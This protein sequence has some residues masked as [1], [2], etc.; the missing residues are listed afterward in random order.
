MTVGTVVYFHYNYTMCSMDLCVWLISRSSTDNLVWCKI[1]N[2]ILVSD[3]THRQYR[4]KMNISDKADSLMLNARVT[5]VKRPT[6]L[7]SSK[8]MLDCLSFYKLWCNKK[9]RFSRS[10]LF[11]IQFEFVSVSISNCK[12]YVAKIRL[13]FDYMI[14]TCPII[15]EIHHWREKKVGSCLF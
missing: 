12:C 9:D 8:G 6:H 7:C 13:L 10:S 1:N 4:E 5:Y 11:N 2:L 3:K 14:K 15:I